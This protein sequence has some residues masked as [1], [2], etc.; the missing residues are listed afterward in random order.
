M[1]IWSYENQKVKSSVISK[2]SRTIVK[3]SPIANKT[4]SFL[5]MNRER[6][7]SSTY[8]FTSP[9]TQNNFEDE[10]FTFRN[11][12]FKSP[13]NLKTNFQKFI[14][15][16][17]SN[18][19]KTESQ[20]VS[21]KSSFIGWTTPKN[22]NSSNSNKALNTSKN[23]IPKTFI[24]LSPLSK[25]IENRCN[26][27]LLE[28]DP[29]SDHYNSSK[30]NF[31]K[32]RNMIKRQVTPNACKNLVYSPLRE[33]SNRSLFQSSRDNCVAKTLI[34]QKRTETLPLSASI[35]SKMKKGNKDLSSTSTYETKPYQRTKL[36]SIKNL[37]HMAVSKFILSSRAKRANKDQ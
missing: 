26:S 6:S 16:T 22:L 35:I 14:S 30:F 29:S 17:I 15:S 1:G 3:R 12:S 2:V 34:F 8:K 33:N 18:H 4:R 36:S 21:A 24:K 37:E 23:Q 7:D 13:E 9:P 31:N 5:V 20:N 27:A 10:Y 11:W 32:S 25:R 19:P 28:I